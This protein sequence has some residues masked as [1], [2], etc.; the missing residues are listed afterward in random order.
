[1]SVWV[2]VVAALAG[3]VVGGLIAWWIEERRWKRE[4]AT[5]WDDPRR[6]AY[7]RFLG[8]SLRFSYR[9]NGFVSRRDFR[10]NL[11]YIRQLSEAV[12]NTMAEAD[13]LATDEVKNAADG[14]TS[15][16]LD[17][18]EHSTALYTQSWLR[19]WR[20]PGGAEHD[21]LQKALGEQRKAFSA[22]VHK[23]LGIP[24]A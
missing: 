24:A 12:I 14:V 22:A 11:E 15:A 9:W 16:V 19:Q 10:K 21:R 8:A 17:I 6:V 7:A 2:P 3:T 1:M 13:L 20:L 23:E 4:T 18:V 5:R